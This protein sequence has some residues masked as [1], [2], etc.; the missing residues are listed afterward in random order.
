M[1]QVTF[2]QE[3][4]IYVMASVWTGYYF[5]TTFKFGVVKG[6]SKSM[7]AFAALYGVIFVMAFASSIELL[8]GIVTGVIANEAS[9]KINKNRD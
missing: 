6:M 3:V 8:V 4:I 7:W 1:N 5:Y 9:R 2:L